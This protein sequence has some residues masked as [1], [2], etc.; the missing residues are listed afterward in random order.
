MSETNTNTALQSDIEFGRALLT[1]M[2]SPP[3]KPIYPPTGAKRRRPIDPVPISDEEFVKSLKSENFAASDPV[4]LMKMFMNIRLDDYIQ[5]LTEV[6][7]PQ[8]LRDYDPRNVLQFLKNLSTLEPN[9]DSSNLT[10]GML[11]YMGS[12]INRDRSKD[13][14]YNKTRFKY[15]SKFLAEAD[16]DVIVYIVS[17]LI[18][19]PL[20]L[21]SDSKKGINDYAQ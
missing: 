6:G 20:L 8:L 16:S 19:T 14:F 2:N 15:R 12:E 17:K 1:K 4:T 11:L 5:Y 7:D 13:S 21:I 10:I 3:P 9:F 18:F